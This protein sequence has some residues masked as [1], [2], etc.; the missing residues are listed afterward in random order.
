[1]IERLML[2]ARDNLILQSLAQAAEIVAVS[3]YTD[4]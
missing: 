1:M 4:N 3:G 2:C